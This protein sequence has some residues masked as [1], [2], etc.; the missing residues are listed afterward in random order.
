MLSANRK[1]LIIIEGPDG[2]GKSTL[3]NSIVTR[4]ASRQKDVATVHHGSYPGDDQI[5]KHFF[6]SMLPAY[7]ETIDVVLDRTWISDPIYGQVYRNGLNRIEPWQARLLRHVEMECNTFFIWCLPPVEECVKTFMARKEQEML[8]DADQLR[9]VY[10]LYMDT[11]KLAGNS[12]WYD[13]TRTST[14][15]VFN[16]VG[17]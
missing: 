10:Q 1:K 14:K 7:R 12:Y 4:Y 5:W 6:D 15:E 9:R 2:G 11:P 13:Y 3:V 8:D 16:Y 17:I